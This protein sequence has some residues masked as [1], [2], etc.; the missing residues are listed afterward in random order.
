[1]RRIR[2][3]RVKL[4]CKWI[5]FCAFE[6]FSCALITLA[7]VIGFAIHR[8]RTCLTVVT[9]SAASFHSISEIVDAFWQ[10]IRLIE[11]CMQIFASRT[12]QWNRAHFHRKY[13]SIQI[14]KQLTNETRNANSNAFAFCTHSWLV[15]RNKYAYWFVRQTYMQ[16]R[17]RDWGDVAKQGMRV[18]GIR[19]SYS[20]AFAGAVFRRCMTDWSWI[21]R[22]ALCLIV[23]VIA[24]QTVR[25][26]FA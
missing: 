21:T 19:R 2:C 6:C 23:M 25:A 17:L 24:L 7:A 1:M 3:E 15:Y 5:H 11:R 13:D 20:A 4:L 18:I 26:I 12:F 8:R 22:I 9:V 16:S 14:E 10:M